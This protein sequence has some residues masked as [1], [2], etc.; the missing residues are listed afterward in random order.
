MQWFQHKGI[1]VFFLLV[2]CLVIFFGGKQWG[3]QQNLSL[4][5]PPVTW[6]ETQA[7]QQEPIAPQW[8]GFGKVMAWRDWQAISP[9]SGRVI[10]RHDLLEKGHFLPQDT[11]VVTVDPE[12]YQRAVAQIQ[13]SLRGLLAQQ[14]RVEQESLFIEQDLAL[15]N[16]QLALA[17]KAWQRSQSLQ[18]RGAVSRSKVEQDQQTYLNARQ[19]WQALNKQKGL[20]PSQRDQIQAQIEQ[21]TQ[22]L[23][24]AKADLMETDIRL[25]FSGQVQRVSVRDRQWVSAQ[26]TLFTL[27]DTQDVQIQ[28]P[29]AAQEWQGLG[30]T[31]DPKRLERALNSS[32]PVLAEV[33]IDDTLWL[34]R[35]VRIEDSV[36]DA[37]KWLAIVRLTRPENA[38]ALPKVG[39]LVSV[40]LKGTPQLHW[41]VPESSIHQNCVYVM[42]EGSLRIVPITPL[43]RVGHRVAISGDLSA[44][45]A[46]I[47]TPLLPAIDGM[48]VQKKEEDPV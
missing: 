26:S 48:K 6:V 27:L 32:D 14:R 7:L 41:V 18:E 29:I 35:V 16:E 10:F 3:K 15:E 33:K 30:V 24:Q 37:Q 13:A 19:R 21:E 12:K 31:G 11:L 46:L 8:Q 40:A 23:A 1:W 43:F 44:D 5:T 39:R 45:D 2:A 42:K 47:L 34:G 17:E 36:T 4:K 28:V 9:I 25:P 22:R 20:L 38:P